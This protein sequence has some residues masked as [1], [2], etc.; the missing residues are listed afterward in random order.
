M[1]KDLK[2]IKLEYHQKELSFESLA[3]NPH[4]EIIKWMDQAIDNKVS[5]PNNAI[6]ATVDSQGSP[7]SRVILIKDINEKGIT[8]FTNYDS[9]KAQHI[10]KNPHVSLTIFWK[11]M[12]RQIRV[13][14]IATKTSREVSKKYFSSRSK[15][16]QISAIASPQSSPISKEDLDKAVQAIKDSDKIECPLNWGGYLLS[17]EECEFWQGRPNRLHDRFLFKKD[18]DNWQTCRLA[19]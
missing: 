3:D 14:A 16:S 5:Y 19:P 7:S 12:D 8:F 10:K 11:E 2:S 9:E 1:N 15:E 6:I 17:I 4:E 13:K 18:N